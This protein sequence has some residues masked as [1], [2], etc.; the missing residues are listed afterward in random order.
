MSVSV[1]GN[2]FV[3]GK[4]VSLAVTEISAVPA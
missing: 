4:E 2:G 1:T 3:D